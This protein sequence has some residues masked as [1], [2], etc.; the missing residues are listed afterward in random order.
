MTKKT[1]IVTGASRGIGAATARLAGANGY[2]VC[3]NYL[4]NQA[5]AQAVV[6]D[7]HSH[8]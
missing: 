6:A 3:V 8:G 2:Q 7:I 4:A 1:L 5:A